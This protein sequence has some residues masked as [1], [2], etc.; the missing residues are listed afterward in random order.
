MKVGLLTFSCADN[1][2]A[3]LQCYALEE[4]LRDIGS[5]VEVIN[6]CPYYLTDSYGVL[7]NPLDF[8]T[9]HGLYHTLT[10]IRYEF[11]NY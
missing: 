5:E 8:I 7:H 9:R 4:Y 2:G 10:R 1:V 11:F 3:V 6:Y